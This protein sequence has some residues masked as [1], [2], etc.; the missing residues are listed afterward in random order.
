MRN[1]YLVLILCCLVGCNHKTEEGKSLMVTHESIQ[2]KND[3]L[4]KPGPIIELDKKIVG[5]D[6]E[7]DSCL[8]YIDIETDSLYRFGP[9]GV[10]SGEFIYPYT[11]QHL[12]KNRFG[13]FDLQARKYTQIQIK[14]HQIHMETPVPVTNDKTSQS[15][16]VKQISSNSYLGIGMYPKEMF[17]FMDSLNNTKS[18][19][20]EF[21]YKDSS[22]KALKNR[23][24]A[25]AYQ[26]RLVLNTD[27][28]RLAFTSIWGEIFHIYKVE[29]D[30]L[31][32]LNKSEKVYPKYTV[33][34]SQDGYSAP[35]YGSNIVGYISSTANNQYI[36]LL[37]SG[38]KLE[39][40]AKA[41]KEFDASTIHVFNW[42]GEK[43]QTFTLDI[44]CTN[45]CISS[46]SQVLW[47]IANNPDPELV[48]FNLPTIE[49]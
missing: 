26:G 36:Y 35:M 5:I 1:V 43:V 3:Y 14:N 6:Y 40:Y 32:L 28:N 20:F 37:Y 21:P 17:V 12:D 34:D 39:D 18:S 48:K 31:I 30:S 47:A 42:E 8:F 10:G 24:R 2:L 49:K 13:I 27:R 33:E 25:M 9:R 29:K 4:G 7:L 22:E 23:L 15:F 38:T 45:I 19:F 44:P 11:I 46:D 41:L 16:D